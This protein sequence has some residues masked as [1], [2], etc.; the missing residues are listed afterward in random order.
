MVSLVSVLG[1]ASPGLNPLSAPVWNAVHQLPQ[2]VQVQVVPLFL[3]SNGELI[4]A[5]YSWLLHVNSPLKHIP[6][7]LYHVQ[8]CRMHLPVLSDDVVGLFVGCDDSGT[9]ALSVVIHK[10]K[11]CGLVSLL[12]GQ[13]DV[14]QNFTSVLGGGHVA[15]DDLQSGLIV[16]DKACPH[17]DGPTTL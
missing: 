2:F 11:V 8:F 6:G 3:D 10:V 12:E 4:Q 16:V 7:V 15:F 1:V 5:V 13:D 9:M 14:K 17:P